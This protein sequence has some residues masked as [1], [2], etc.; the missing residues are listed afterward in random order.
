MTEEKAEVEALGKEYKAYIAGLRRTWL[1][2][3]RFHSRDVFEVM[4]PA[5]QKEVRRRI[6]QW[7]LHVTP[8]VEEWWR[9]RGYGVA[10]PAHSSEPMKVF[11]LASV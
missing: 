6:D 9:Q 2:E 10:W 3:N 7:A 11:K 8:L 5:E 1:A 4:A